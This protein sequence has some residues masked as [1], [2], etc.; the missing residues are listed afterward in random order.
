[1]WLLNKIF[2]IFYSSMIKQKEY[3]DIRIVGIG[4]MSIIFTFNVITL[5]KIFKY[6]VSFF[7]FLAVFV[8]LNMTFG[9]FFFNKE[10]VSLILKTQNKVNFIEKS[11]VVIYMFLSLFLFIYVSSKMG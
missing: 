5:I 8:I 10:K 6:N 3:R 1:M 4:L 7:V 2:F 11:I 9:L